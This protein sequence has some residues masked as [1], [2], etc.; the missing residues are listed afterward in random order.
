MG[1]SGLQDTDL[2]VNLPGDPLERRVAR[3]R[4]R[5][6]LWQ[7]EE[8]DDE[9]KVEKIIKKV[10][11]RT[12][13]KDSKLLPTGSFE[14]YILRVEDKTI[15]VGKGGGSCSVC[16]MYHGHEVLDEER[17]EQRK[18]CQRPQHLQR[19]RRHGCKERQ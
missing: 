7:Q 9:E 17:R 3:T 4:L 11:E 19:S 10:Q 5:L 1:R 8:D 12:K 2:M 16:F 14:V 15:Y 13:E 6:R 18:A